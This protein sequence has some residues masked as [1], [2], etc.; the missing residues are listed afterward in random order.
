[1][2]LTDDQGNPYPA[3]LFEWSIL[4]SIDWVERELDVKLRPE[5]VSWE[6]HDYHAVDYQQWMF[7]KTKRAPIIDDL[8]DA[9]LTSRQNDLTRVR[10]VWPNG[11]SVIEFDQRWIQLREE[12]GHINIVPVSGTIDS[13]LLTQAGNFLPLL[14]GGISFIPNMIQVQYTAGFREGEVPYS[15]RELCGKKAAFGP[16][17]IAGDLIVGAGI[18]SQSVSM[19]GLSQSI[20][21]TSSATNSGYGARLVQYT[22]EIKEQLPSLRRNLKGLPLVVV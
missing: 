19:D 2:D 5:Q 18:A 16:L 3:R 6:K 15:I 17:N 14:S 10:V 4:F 13:V 7:L 11:D 1:V 8:S 9:D 20:G 12:L 22:K 21:T